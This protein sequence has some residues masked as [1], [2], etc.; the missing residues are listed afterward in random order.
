MKILYSCYIYFFLISSFLLVSLIT[1]QLKKTLKLEKHKMTFDNF[2]LLAYSVLQL[3]ET[4]KTGHCI[5]ID[6]R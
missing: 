3:N 6:R 5:T 2:Y 1:D 4:G